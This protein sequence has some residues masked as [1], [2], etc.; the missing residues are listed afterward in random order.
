MTEYRL[1][2]ADIMDLRASIRWHLTDPLT[3]FEAPFICYA[4]ED[5]MA[6]NAPG[7]HPDAFVIHTEGHIRAISPRIEVL[8]A[9]L[10]CEWAEPGF[11][12]R[13]LNPAVDCH[14]ASLTPDE[15]AALRSR[16][17]FE[18]KAM[19]TFAAEEA[20]QRKHSV[21]P[22]RP[23]TDIPQAQAWLDGSEDIEDV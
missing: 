15:S 21:K 2:P 12:K 18:E 10:K 5:R 11:M 6:Q 9:C 20:R 14:E 8:A 7:Y 17:L 4:R 13:I 3:S 1:T 22:H 19:R 23:T 16:R